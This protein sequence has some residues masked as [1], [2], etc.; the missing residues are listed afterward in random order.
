M[1]VRLPQALEE[2]NM[3]ATGVLVYLFLVVGAEQAPIPS[4]AEVEKA[5]LEQRRAIVRGSAT[6]KA[7]NEKTSGKGGY[8]IKLWFD[9]ER[10]RIRSDKWWRKEDGT[11][12]ARHIDCRNCE[13]DGFLISHVEEKIPNATLALTLTK[14]DATSKAALLDIVDLRLVGM[15]PTQAGSLI[16][17]NME[18]FLT[19]PDR[20]VP[21]MKQDVWKGQD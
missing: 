8:I 6:L 9:K 20:E 10:N 7:S 18:S 1:V 19:R 2:T 17:F 4:V 5:A 3:Q 13:K 12:T 15:A 16:Y 14:M 11:S 21:S